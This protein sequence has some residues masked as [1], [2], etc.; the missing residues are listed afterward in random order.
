GGP[1]SAI[2][3]SIFYRIGAFS[4]RRRRRVLLVWVVVLFAAFPAVKSLSNN[5]SQGGFEVPGSQSDQV[6]HDIDTVFSRNQAQFND[7]LVMHSD[8]L[9]ATEAAFKSAVEGELA[10]LRRAP[11]LAWS[12]IVD[13]YSA[14]NR[15]ISGDG[16]TLTVSL[17]LA[18]NQDQALKHDPTVEAIVERAA[19]GTGIKTLLTGDA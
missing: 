4:Y 8:T 14:P 9:T 2:R 6:K 18:D 17:P 5:L 15:F 13:P 10:A 7:L 1:S 3:E 11:G 16:H 19:S 12:K